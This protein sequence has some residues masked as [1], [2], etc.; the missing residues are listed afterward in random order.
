MTKPAAAIIIAALLIA[1]IPA[2]A[3]AA[4]RIE[5]VQYDSP[6]ADYGSN[7]SLN[8]EWVRIRNTGPTARTLTG[9]TVRD[10]SGHVYRF[11]TLRLPKG[12]AVTL[13]TGRGSNTGHHRYWGS[14]SYVWNN[15]G[16]KATLKT[17]GG[18]FADSCRWSGGATATAC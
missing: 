8:A 12:E 10:N 17:S 6:G 4:V 15:T 13:H 14:G 11:G 9:W 2:Q 3:L 5:R 7:P 18:N 16:D 1:A